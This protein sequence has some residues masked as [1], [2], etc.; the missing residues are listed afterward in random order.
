MYIIHHVM[1]MYIYVYIYMYFFVLYLPDSVECL[2]QFC[3]LEWMIDGT[4]AC[5][6]DRPWDGSKDKIFTGAYIQWH[7]CTYTH[8]HTYHIWQGP[9]PHP[10]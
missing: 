1:Y 9:Y 8:T 10:D 7:T 2:A 3:N 4:N 5:M 6:Y